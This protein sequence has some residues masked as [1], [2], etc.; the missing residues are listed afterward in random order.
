MTDN[1]L[2][3]QLE[4]LFADTVPEPGAETEAGEAE[5]LVEE[6]IVSL[7]GG[8]AEAKLAAVGPMAV[9]VPSPILAKPEEAKEAYGPP[10]IPPK[11]IRF[12][13]V[14]LGE[15]RTNIYDILLR[16]V[17]ILG[18]VLLAFL[19]IRLMWQEPSGA[20]LPSL[21]FAAYTV[22]LAI[23]LLQWMFNSSSTRALREAGERVTEA[24]RSQT[25]LEERA[26]ELATANA[27]LQKR[28]LQLQA[29]DQIS[30]AVA[31]VLDPN[32]LAQQAV[33]LIRERFD[34]YYVGLFLIDESERWAVLQAGT[35][36]AGRRMLARDYK[37]EID[38]TS[39]VGWC[40]ANAQVRIAPGPDV[41]DSNGRTEHSTEPP[42]GSLS[43]VNS[44][45]P[46][47]R[48]KMAL[49]LR[50][51]GQVIG[52]LD[53]Q[54]TGREAF[55]QEDIAV[56]QA[57]A[58][59]VAVAIDNAQLF[60]EIQ[61]RLEE[62][63][64]SQRQSAR[65]QWTDIA[66]TRA[67]TSYERARPDAIPLE[68]AATS[69]DISALDRVIEQAMARREAVVQSNTGNGTEQAA[70]VVPIS[71]R[72]E[73]LGALGL[74]E[75]GGKRRWTDDEIALIEAVADQMALAIE[76][77]RLLEET[78]RRARQE[79]HVADISARVRSST[80]VDTILRTAIREL[81]RTLRASDGL[82]RLGSGDETASLQTDNEA[83][84]DDNAN[85]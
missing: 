51:R 28:T 12:W 6:A 14:T 27:L 33:N 64:T 58:E 80:E 56:L 62:M 47:A 55:S 81:G 77:A 49:P 78:Q 37:V 76:N 73:P 84:D 24:T 23:L 30:Q 83:V 50:S 22:A 44:L 34:L 69:G 21:Y 54:S 63:E 65:E 61:A 15:Q 16:S 17:T 53:V 41:M 42:R 48:S 43:D 68:D 35:G 20:G 5:L 8:E 79:R 19:L 70:L 10:Q 57:V 66:P 25:I 72:G 45:L 26:D 7:L 74:H 29:A 9:E 75:T 60:A 59:R 85:I 46:E 38:D 71:L 1:D 40:M 11:R 3:S 4:G 2:R 13:K 82:I 36:E 67:V 39:T 18:G 31:S 52:A 32:E